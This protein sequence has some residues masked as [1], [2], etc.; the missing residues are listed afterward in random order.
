MYNKYCIINYNMYFLIILF[1]IV[2]IKLYFNINSKE[3]FLLFTPEPTSD[4]IETET[5]AELTESD[6]LKAYY[7]DKIFEKFQDLENLRNNIEDVKNETI[8]INIKSEQ[9]DKINSKNK[10]RL[11]N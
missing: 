10:L 11:I 9:L 3:Q 1:I 4:P 6:E 2:L 7:I 5:K 8:N